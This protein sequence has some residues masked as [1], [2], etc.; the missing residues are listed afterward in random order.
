MRNKAF[1]FNGKRGIAQ[2]C[3]SLLHNWDLNTHRPYE[4]FR[5]RTGGLAWR[6]R[7]V[8]VIRAM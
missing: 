3:S 2:L 5:T 6:T 4:T 1:H 7:D 8:V